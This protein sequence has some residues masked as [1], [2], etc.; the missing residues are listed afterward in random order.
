MGWG[1]NKGFYMPFLPINNTEGTLKDQAEHDHVGQT[2][3]SCPFCSETSE[4]ED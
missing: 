2:S 4:T 1:C 3:F